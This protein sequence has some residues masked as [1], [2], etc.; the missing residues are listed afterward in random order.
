MGIVD[1]TCTIWLIFCDDYRFY[2]LT[3]GS[4]IDCPYLLPDLWLEPQGAPPQVVVPSFYNIATGG[5][6]FDRISLLF[7]AC[8]ASLFAH[9]DTKTMDTKIFDR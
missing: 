4:V 2:S 1:F 3:Y 9:L 7:C 8:L 6:I 5:Y